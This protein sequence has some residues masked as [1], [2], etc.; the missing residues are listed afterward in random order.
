MSI[1]AAIALVRSQPEAAWELA[2]L[3]PRQGEWS[4]EKYL[5][6]SNRSRRLVEFADGYVE[7]LPMPTEE[8]QRILMCLYRVL[9]AFLAGMRRALVLTAGLRVRVSPERFREPEL[10]ALLDRDDPRRGNDYWSGADLVAE[11]V[12]P[13]DPG[14]DLVHK[15]SEYAQPASPSIGLSIHR[16][17]R[18]R[19]CDWRPGGMSNTGYFGA[20]P[21]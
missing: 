17:R 9:Y 12:S 18:S 4:T 7:V 20:A 14:R 11:I 8:H 21:L 15:R 2:P 13:D 1:E 16:R 19:C 10:V 5:W 3:L 6:L